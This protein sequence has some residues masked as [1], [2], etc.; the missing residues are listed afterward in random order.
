MRKIASDSEK[1]EEIW[2]GGEA[3]DRLRDFQEHSANDI[4]LRRAYTDNGA[5]MSYAFKS[6]APRRVN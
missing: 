5:A 3:F 4:L 1:I 6:N 2:T